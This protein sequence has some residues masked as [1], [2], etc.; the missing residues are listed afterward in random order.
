MSNI[1]KDIN[2]IQKFNM[3]TYMSSVMEERAIAD[4]RDG[5]KPVQRYIIWYMINK[6]IVSSKPHVKSA[7]V[8]GA[9]IGEYSPH[10]D[11]TTFEALSRLTQK[12]SLNVPLLNPHGSFGSINGDAPAS[13]RYNE[14]RLDKFTEKCTELINKNS[15]DFVPNYDNTKIEPI[16]LPMPICLLLINGSYGIACGFAQSV[17]P[18]NLID[19]CNL[20]KELIDNSNL[21]DSEVANKIKPDFPT[22]GI[23]CN[24]DDITKAYIEGKGSFKLRGK[25]EIK[26][27]KNG[28]SDIII[29]NIPFQVT[30]GPRMT[31]TA[32]K[33]GGLINSIVKKIK[34]GTIEGI[35]DI[36]DYSSGMKINIIIKIKKGV[37]PEIV[38]NKLYKY[39]LLE[40]TQNIN[41]ICNNNKIFNNYSI[42]RIIT[43]FISYRIN[44]IRRSIIFD[45]DKYNKRSHIIDG[46]IVALNDI[47]NV[48]KIIK[49]SN[50]KDECKMSLKNKYN[51]TDIQIDYVLS[52]KLSSLMKLEINKL[53]QEKIDIENNLKELKNNLKDEN[54][55]KRIK[56]EQD[57]F[58]KNYG[59]ERLTKLENLNTNIE[60]E[61]II[62]NEPT[63]VLIDNNN[64]IKRVNNNFKVQKR[65]TKGIN[66]D[67]NIRD[68]FNTNTKDHLLCF[69]NKGRVYDIKVHNIKESNNLNS[70][71]YKIENLIKLRPDEI[72]KNILCINNDDFNNKNSQL[73]FLTK[74]GYIKRTNLEYFNNINSSGIIALSMKEDELISANYVV[75]SN[76]KNIIN[77]IILCTKKGQVVRYVLNDIPNLKRDTMGSIA[78][79][80]AEDDCCIG[81]DIIKDINDLVFFGT[82]MGLGK[83][84]K[85]TD[86]VEKKDSNT[87]KL[88][89]INDGFPILKRS[90]NIKGRLGIKLN[91]ND[92]VISIKIVNKEVK[93]FIIITNNKFVNIESDDI[94]N[95]PIKRPTMGRKLLNLD[96]NDFVK[97]I[98]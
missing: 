50:N 41:L 78:I 68:I 44:C 81:F 27:N 53:K 33:D 90:A 93:S 66:F 13:M 48:I 45:I 26:E 12:F 74:K 17:P 57:W 84:V 55:K 43:E 9:V 20:T 61:D 96:D 86:M 19:V 62:E 97:I 4:I 31:A 1:K 28:T 8:V 6:G 64:Y 25:A 38:L 79:K 15:I 11:A 23:I 73:V 36:Q 32:S 70:K 94:I 76:N 22:G 87:K 88:V 92:E 16:S 85:V 95:N 91:N 80:L 5:L 30:I 63:T 10:G 89:T 56:E 35:N 21:S 14:I 71:G 69:T 77:D 65:N 7:A 42:K 83:T 59:R 58:I 54:I 46:L 52:T 75:E 2:E 67:N 98:R 34:D 82:K 3:M 47:D 51:L 39:T 60:I 72:V 37:N 24:S 29:T 18:H 40:T 49:T